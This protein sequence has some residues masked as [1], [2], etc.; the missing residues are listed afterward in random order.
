MKAL[1]DGRNV[2]YFMV[3]L[4]ERNNIIFVLVQSCLVII[5]SFNYLK[6]F[7]IIYSTCKSICLHEC[8][9]TMQSSALVGGK[10]NQIHRR[11]SSQGL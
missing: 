2:A 7:G 10:K 3:L 6:K 1:L 4:H 5:P 8:M 11:W 9:C